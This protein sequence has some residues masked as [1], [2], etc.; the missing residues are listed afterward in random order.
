MKKVVTLFVLFLSVGVYAQIG[1]GTTSSEAPND[2]PDFTP[3]SPQAGAITQYGDLPIN[4]STGK[5]TANVPIHTFSAGQ[6]QLPIT[7]NYIGNGVKVDANNTWTGVNWTL[8]AGGVITR[9]VNH[10][11]DEQVNQRVFQEDIDL[12]NITNE[13]DEAV[14]I[15]QYYN[16]T[17]LTWDTQPDIFSFSFPGY[18]GSF[19]LSQ[20]DMSPIL[21]NVDSELEIEILGSQN[22]NRLKLLQQK[23]FK[24]TTPDGIQYYFGDIATEETMLDQNYHDVVTPRAVT[25]FY[26][27]QIVHPINGRIYLEY[28]DVGSYRLLTSQS[29][30]IVK[31]QADPELGYYSGCGD[32]PNCEPLEESSG[33]NYAASK[34]FTRVY[35]GKFLKKIRSPFTNEEVIFNHTNLID[36]GFNFERVL[37][38]VQVHK[39][40]T[41]FQNIDLEYIFAYGNNIGQRFF[42]EKVI[43][44]KEFE[45]GSGVGGRQH[46]EFNFEYYDPLGL[47]AR[48]ANSQDALGFYNG[49]NNQYGLLP[50][51]SDLP[52]GYGSASQVLSGLGYATADR[53]T[54][55]NY[56]VKGALKKMYYPTGGHTLFEYEGEIAKE[57]KFEH[58]YIRTFRNNYPFEDGSGAYYNDKLSEF[59]YLGY[60]ELLSDGDTPSSTQNGV[61]TDQTIEITVKV[62]ALDYTRDR[63]KVFIIDLGDPTTQSDDTLVHTESIVMIYPDGFDPT[64]EE[65]RVFSYNFQEGK[66][67]KIELRLPTPVN[68]SAPSMTASL[69]FDYNVGYQLV[70]GEGLRVKRLSDFVSN[71]E[72]ATPQNIKRYY[73]TRVENVL[74]NPADYVAVYRKPIFHEQVSLLK[75]CNVWEMTNIPCENG[76]PPRVFSP[77]PFAGSIDSH[78][79]Y[80]LG[81]HPTNYSENVINNHKVVTISYGGDT[82]ENGG[83]E[84]RFIKDIG[85]SVLI[86]HVPEISTMAFNGII[87]AHSGASWLNLRHG[88][89]LTEKVLKK[90][91]DTLFKISETQYSY[92]NKTRSFQKVVVG[93]AH[94]NH[95]AGAYVPYSHVGLGLYEIQ[96]KE[97]AVNATT[98]TTYMD[99]I[100]VAWEG[101]TAPRNPYNYPGWEVQDHDNDGVQ[102]YLDAEYLFLQENWDG[103]IDESDYRKVITQTSYEYNSYAGQPTKTTVST[104]INGK[105]QGTIVKYLDEAA[106]VASSSQELT[107]YQAILHSKRINTPIQSESFVEEGGAI[108]TLSR[109]KT[110]FDSYEGNVLPSAIHSAK[111]EDTFEE[112]VVFEKYNSAGNLIEVKAA[113]GTITQYQYN[114]HN[115]VTRKIENYIPSTTTFPEGDN[116]PILCQFVADTFP[117]SLVSFYFYDPLTNLMTHMIDPSCNSIYYEYDNLY[118]LKYVKD[119]NG[120]I[121]SKNEYNFTAQN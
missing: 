59:V 99:C 35:G 71:S 26:L 2:L 15:Y 3:P 72:N 85:N 66:I 75:K 57:I 70:E 92:Q 108:S 88:K 23:E 41:L 5:A 114:V 56:K 97:V 107:N 55:L 61:F 27:T 62:H 42:L 90:E 115:Q 46:R 33:Q 120:N 8:D 9:T 21:I 12:L 24:I 78:R 22:T 91:N 100:P 18:S 52:T 82:F 10:K 74:K 34:V 17:G 20:D 76:S 58:K 98:Q 68:Q 109:S 64:Y 11:P 39:G 32:P 53:S 63:T 48:F 111:G 93:S 51:V 80:T 16:S 89:T 106:A 101:V 38:G 73:Y 65:E 6:L 14:V 13:Q 84:K 81:I 95:G 102:N 87:K 94:T 118:R 103:S 49:K 83:I 28:D 4:E 37:E 67:Y 19:Y 40:S 60:P 121:L 119:Q 47:P 69:S 86:T 116:L 31:Y 29:K 113:N 77:L 54:D 7:M 1:D 104:S 96:S 112:R 79:G 105:R 44:N 50:D 36:G 117:R 25:S 110:V 43:F 30:T 45:S